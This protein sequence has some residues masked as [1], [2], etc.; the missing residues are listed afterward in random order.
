MHPKKEKKEKITQRI[1]R[2]IIRVQE[3]VR[4]FNKFS[5]LIIDL[6]AEI[7]I[8]IIFVTSN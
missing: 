2:R 1:L 6:F 3:S 4:K 8:N 7:I 5:F